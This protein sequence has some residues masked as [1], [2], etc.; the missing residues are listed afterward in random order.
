MKSLI[1]TT[2]KSSKL[3]ENKSTTDEKG[4]DLFSTSNKILSEN[5]VAY[6]TLS[7]LKFNK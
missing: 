4:V 6:K 1:F 5:I 7:N 2:N 3:K